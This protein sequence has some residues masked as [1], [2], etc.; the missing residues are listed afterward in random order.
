MILFFLTDSDTQT[1]G[2]T[3][4]D[5]SPDGG[6]FGREGVGMTTFLFLHAVFDTVFSVNVY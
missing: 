3:W 2:K 1:L 4:N 6:Y 5:I